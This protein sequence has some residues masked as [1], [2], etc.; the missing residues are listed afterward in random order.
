MPTKKKLV[1]RKPTRRRARKKSRALT[2][3][4]A[5]GRTAGRVR[6]N[7]GGAVAAV[8]SPAKRAA[9]GKR[10]KRAVSR[11]F[12]KKGPVAKNARK[13]AAVAG[14]LAAT[15]AAVVVARKRR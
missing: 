14:A 6:R 5:L 9:A 4:E 7:V 11:T 15:A 2:A 8:R 1:S 3:A 13:I 12:A 10:F